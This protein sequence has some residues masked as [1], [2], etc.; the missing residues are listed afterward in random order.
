MASST[1]MRRTSKTQAD[2]ARMGAALCLTGIARGVLVLALSCGTALAQGTSPA[3]APNAASSSAATVPATVGTASGTAATSTAGGA[4]LPEVKVTAER[5]VTSLKRTP[6]SVGV[7]GRN[8]FTTGGTP[9]PADLNGATASLV[10]GGPSQRSAGSGGIYIRGIGT[11][12]PTYSSAVALYVDDVYI[13]R[14]IGNGL[15]MAYPDIERVEILRGPQGTLYGEN[16]SAGARKVISRDPTD[17]SAWVQATAGSYGA[18]GVKGY[19]SRVVVPDMLYFGIA[20]GRYRDDGY[21]YDP[22]LRRQVDA[23]NTEL[24]RGKIRF[25]PTKDFEALFTYDITRDRSDSYSY[26]APNYPGSGIRTTYENTDPAIDR[27]LAGMSL[28][29][30]EKIDDHLTVKSI[31]AHRWISD[32]KYPLTQD[33]VPTDLYGWLLNI[34]QH[35]TS[36]EFQLAGDYGPLQ[37]TSGVVWFGESFSSFRPSWT[38]NV[39]KGIQ[40]NVY[41]RSAA[42]YTQAH[43]QFTPKL[44]ITAGVRYNRD[45]Q[46]YNNTGFN[47]NASLVPLARTFA[48]GDLYQNV[49]SW[50]PKI[51]ID[52]QWTPDLFSY[53]SITKGEKSGGYNPVAAT[54]A[55]S[56]VPVAPEKVLTYEVGNK[57]TAWGG[58]AQLNTALFYNDFE[59]YQAAI[60]NAIINGQ[61]IN[62]SVTVNAGKAQTYGA[63]FELTT[64]PFYGLDWNA[65]LTLEQADFRQFVNPT[66]A[67][68]ANYVGNQLPF[69]SHII[70]GTRVQYT[71]PLHL[72]GV[73]RVNATARFLSHTYLDIANQQPLGAQTYVDLGSS[74]TAPGGQWTATFEIHNLLN[75]VYSLGENVN[76]AIGL[77]AYNYSPPRTFLVSLRHD[78]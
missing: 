34:D 18:V 48:T 66:G 12:S 16:S 27:D 4:T 43:Y 72:P 24:F 74:Y 19:V 20:Y 67:A 56:Q 37:F 28:R 53:A 42:I 6:V 30:T 51:G 21:T 32:G 64:R 44:G 52:Y 39:Y 46:T 13:P 45:S 3:V 11:A 10:A 31:T 2:S 50:T 78:F 73:A 47:S 25:T 15:Y 29:L 17:N 14:S 9:L 69:A 26:I 38:N 77:N 76:A 55:I 58:R 36:Q 71:L 54:L 61:L 33:G 35:Q 63:E 62:G 57:I 8:F 49:N 59:N 60:G 41:N 68:G 7:L 70:A 22:V 65:W 5:R 40:S 75:R 1:E 23:T